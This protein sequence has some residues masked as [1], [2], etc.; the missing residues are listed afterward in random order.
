[1][2]SFVRYFGYGIERGMGRWE[3]LKVNSDEL[4]KRRDGDRS[5]LL[6]LW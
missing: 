3:D 2:L 5:S 6:L 4:N 1:M